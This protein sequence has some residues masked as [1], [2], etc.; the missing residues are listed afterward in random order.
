M[1]FII[2]ETLKR[3]VLNQIFQI[4]AMM[5]DNAD[6]FFHLVARQQLDEQAKE[7]QNKKNK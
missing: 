5:Y 2:E 1:H 3:I 7:I 4:T 6:E